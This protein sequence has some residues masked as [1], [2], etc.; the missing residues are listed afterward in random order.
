MSKKKLNQKL[1]QIINDLKAYKPEKVI[2]YGSQARGKAKKHSDI[3]LLI[4]KK[5]NKPFQHRIGIA[6]QLIYKK[7]Y[8]GTPKFPG[9]I[10]IRIYNPREIKKEIKLGN[11]FVE[12]ILDQ[13]K[14]I[15]EK[16]D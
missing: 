7:E 14:V 8:L 12:T 5:T 2:L 15:Y 3:D 11:F 4:V 10:D 13:G 6:Q 9:D 16:R 1:K